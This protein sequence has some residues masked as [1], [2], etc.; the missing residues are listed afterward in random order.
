MFEEPLEELQKSLPPSYRGRDTS[1]IEPRTSRQWCL[2]SWGL[3]VSVCPQQG[4]DGGPLPRSTALGQAERAQGEQ[5]M[6]EVLVPDRPGCPCSPCL[7]RTPCPSPTARRREG[8]E[9]AGPWGD[10][11][12]LGFVRRLC[13][14]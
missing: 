12:L 5:K 11:K 7:L 14:P 8:L 3:G 1:S 6:V 2:R 13:P 4:R 10:A 9:P